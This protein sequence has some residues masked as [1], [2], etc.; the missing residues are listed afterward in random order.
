MAALFGGE[1]LRQVDGPAKRLE[2]ESE[3]LKVYGIIGACGDRQARD[4]ALSG[5]NG[6]LLSEAM[7]Q[8]LVERSG[9][10]LIFP[11]FGK[12][13]AEEITGILDLLG[14]IGFYSGR[15][16]E[17]ISFLLG[18]DRGRAVKTAESLL[19][20][21]NRLFE[22][23]LERIKKTGLSGSAHFQWADIGKRFFPM[24]V[25]AVGLFLEHLISR[26]IAGPDK[27][28]IG[29]Q[30]FP[31]LQPGI[32]DLGISLTKVSARMPPPLRK[33]IETVGIPAFP[34]FMQLIPEAAEA[35]GGIADGCHR[36]AA[37][38]LIDRGSEPAF[39]EN[40]ERVYGRL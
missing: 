38:A 18:K 14:S 30:H 39:I 28:I 35:V 11:A 22:A 2:A 26:E 25:K 9:E 10:E 1:M 40:M 34:D 29:F 7:E 36:Y 21:K 15:T 24:G 16:M 5:V 8:G 3:E 27:Y 20:M 4:G 13:K 33:K 32:G 17:G 19:K 6:M 12:R 37:A 31:Q 23:E